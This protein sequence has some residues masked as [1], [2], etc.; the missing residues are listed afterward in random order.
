MNGKRSR[1]VAVLFVARDRNGRTMDCIE[2]APR[3]GITP[4]KLKK[5]MRRDAAVAS[6]T[7]SNVREYQ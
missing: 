3:G 4:R 6:I 1:I 7:R 5:L 2:I